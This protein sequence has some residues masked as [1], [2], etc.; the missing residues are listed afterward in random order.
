MPVD[1]TTLHA[2]LDGRYVASLATEN[3]DGSM[4]VTPIWYLFADGAF[5]LPT[6]PQT[7]KARN[8]MSRPHASVLVDSR[9]PGPYRAA[10]TGGPARVVDGAEARTVNERVWERYLTPAGRADPSIGGLLEA[11][12]TVCIRVE[13]GRWIWS[14]MGA[15]F[16]GKLE[17]PDLV[18]PLSP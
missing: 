16:G 10:S 8:V 2:F 7:V 12:D 9:G 17:D 11:Y 13:A 14:D 1:E 18:R 6:A 3:G 15:I 4:H 5:Y